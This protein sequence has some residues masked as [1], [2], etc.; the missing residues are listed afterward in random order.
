MPIL[1]LTTDFGDKSFDVAA[2]KGKIMNTSIDTK[3]IDITHN[4]KIYDILNAAYSLKNASINFP[5]K[6]I[7]FTNINLK[8]GNDKML[9]VE[10]DMQ[11]YIC[12]DNG[13]AN[14]MF[15]EED[16]NVYYINDMPINFSY[17][18]VHNKLC[19]IVKF[20]ETNYDITV[21]GTKT[22]SYLRKPLV[23]AAIMPDMI[24][25]SVIYIDR[26]DNA[27]TNISKE[28]FYKYVEDR[29]F[30]ISVR[31]NFVKKICKHYNEVENGEMVC[32]FNSANLLEIAINNSSAVNLL[33]LEHGTL[34]MVEKF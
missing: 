26:Y 6:T 5:A 12:P 14:L 22:N 8:N 25:A 4:I 27:I 30:K 9:I 2:I 10:K 31:S 19:E 3:I 28:M 17:E 21:F 15:P 18:D 1:T 16:I 33:G 23:R 32:I 7:H 13:F 29:P 34:V 20:A 11:Y 24:K